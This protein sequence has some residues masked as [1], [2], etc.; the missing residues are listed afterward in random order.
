MLTACG[1]ERVGPV[2]TARDWFEAIADLN[3]ARAQALTCSRDNQAVEA[4]LTSSGGLNREVDLSDLQVQIQ[5]DLSGLNF[6]DKSNGDDL[7]LV[8]VWGTLN[9]QPVEQEIT[10]VNENDAWKVCTSERSSP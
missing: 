5:I 10:L 9:G 7:A 8:R 2:D 1:V 4:A 3:L 6:E